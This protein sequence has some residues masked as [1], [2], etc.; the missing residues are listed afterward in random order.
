MWSWGDGSN[1]RTG[2]GDE[3]DRN[4]PCQIGALTT[5]SKIHTHYQSGYAIKTDG[6]LWSWGG[7][8]YGELGLG[9][10]TYRSS[11][12]QVG[13]DTN[14]S[15]IGCAGTEAALGLKTDGTLWSW[16]IND[17]GQLGLGDTTHRSSP[18]QIGSLTTWAV[19][20]RPGYA[21]GNS[22][23]AIKSDGT[24]WVWGRNSSG[25]LGLGDR[26]DRSSPVQVGSSSGW[27]RIAIDSSCLG[28]KATG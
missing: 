27:K 22:S 19:L 25:Q 23:A 14:W 16:G 9:D 12:V 11:P 13:S 17:N 24:L 20:N 8:A 18:C 10:R 6:T 7:N 21:L 2:Q 28:V 3:S 5:W 26:T 1:G 15:N 4:S